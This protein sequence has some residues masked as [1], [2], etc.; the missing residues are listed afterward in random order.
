MNY[1]GAKADSETVR[2]Y[3]QGHQAGGG[4]LQAVRVRLTIS[5][6]RSFT[7]IQWCQTHVSHIYF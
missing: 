5:P 6:L 7:S 2:S 1:R 4:I 3:L